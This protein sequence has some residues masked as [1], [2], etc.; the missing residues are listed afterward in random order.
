MNFGV[1][2]Y[3]K[4][5]REQLAQAF[6]EAGHPI[7]AVGSLSGTRPEGFEGTLH[8]TYTDCIN[9]TAVDAIYIATPNLLHVPL[10]IE[11]MRAG[12]PV[13][14]EKPIAMNAHQRGQL[15]AT[16][17]KVGGFV[18]EAFMVEHHPQWAQLP[19]LGIGEQRV[20][21]VQFTYEPRKPNDVRTKAN[22][23]GG[24]W[25]DI[26]CYALFSCYQ[27]GARTLIDIDGRFEAENGVPTRVIARLRFAEG[28]EANVLVTSQHFRHQH[29]Q[30]VADNGV[31]T[32]PR[33]FNPVAPVSN[34]WET[35]EGVR[36]LTS[37]ANQ[38]TRMIEHFV[39][40]AGTAGVAFDERTRLIGE[41]SDQITQHLGF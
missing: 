39:A 33:P 34:T 21:N 19:D 41:W 16:Q 1:L 11:S 20:L 12:K 4:L 29:L 32:M 8:R 18:Q 37:E 17:A 22:L 3:G 26:G 10:C 28:L 36:H 6:E 30:L 2:G 23:G 27:F 13:L 35:P 24:V 5:V 7:V 25:L 38:Y 15:L 9:D 40:H 31:L 14:C